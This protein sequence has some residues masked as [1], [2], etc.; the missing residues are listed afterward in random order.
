[1]F[2][3]AATLCWG[4][5]AT[6]GRAAFTGKLFSGGA[7]PPIDPLI[8]A[9]TR[10]TISLMVL[11]PILFAVRGRAVM[12]MPRADLIRALIIGVVGVAASN[13]FYYLAIQKTNVATA[14]ILQYTAPVWVLLYMVARRLQ[15]ATAW[16]MIAIAL[17]LLGIAL[18][19]DLFH[20]GGLK[21]DRVG[22][23]A[24]FI[25]SLSFACYNI[26]GGALVQKHDRWKALM[27][28]LLGTVLFWVITNPPWRIVAAHYSGTQW[29]FLSVFA[30]TS[31]LLPFSFYFSGL[32]YLDPTRAIVTSCLEP[33]FSILI[34]AAVLGEVMGPWQILGM[35]LV[36]AATLLVQ[37]PERRG[38]A[39]VVVEPME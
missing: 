16:R 1:L 34:A 14:I 38:S 21:I 35:V 7:L 39:V 15:K 18:V 3:A 29:L 8:L 11:A 27:Y 17:A 12:A 37:M 36:L 22:L 2:I 30:I 13:Y 6:L 10:S 23:L 4:I 5:S 24:A 32:H 20:G 33:V 19:I 26:F 28:V 25:A 9:Q 31:V